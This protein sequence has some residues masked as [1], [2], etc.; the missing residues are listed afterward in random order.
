MAEALHCKEAPPFQQLAGCLGASEAS[1][2]ERR[3]QRWLQRHVES[4]KAAA[5]PPR[6]PSL[7]VKL[8]PTLTPTLTLTFVYSSLV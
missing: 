4:K 2:A 6:K 1:T 5:P 7:K 3:G 8:T